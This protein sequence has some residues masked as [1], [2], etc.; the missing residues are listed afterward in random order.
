MNKPLE[1]AGAVS[2]QSAAEASEGDLARQ[3]FETMLKVPG[4]KPGH[5]TVHAK[6]LVCQGTFVPSRE[7][8]TLSKAAHFQGPSVPVT[9]RFSDGAPDPFVPDNTPD[10]GPRGLA[11]RFQPTNGKESDIVSMSQNGFVVGTGEEFLELEKS[12]VTTDPTKP[13]PWPVEVFLSTHPRALKF[14]QEKGIVPASFANEAFFSNNAFVFVNDKGTRQAMRY[15]FLPVAGKRQLSD[16][17]AKAKPVNFL[18]DDLKARLAHGPVEWR[19]VAQLP[20]PGDPTKDSTLVW[21]EDRKTVELGKV[22]VVSMVPDNA[23][24]ENRLAFF[25]T[26]L[27][28]GIELSDDPLP[29]LRSRVYLLAST[30]RQ[31]K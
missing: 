19:L 12:I 24:A 31:R 27:T 20:N 26:N 16:E 29:E 13:H 23:E 9:V 14:V 28:T 18:F 30:L 15:Q 1:E 3:I 17:E 2:G 4:N 22:S 25:P 6:G 11:I 21:P 5:R 8:A 10:A 7:A